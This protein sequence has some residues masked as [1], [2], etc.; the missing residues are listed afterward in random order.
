M[1]RIKRYPALILAALLLLSGC[2]QTAQEITNEE[3]AAYTAEV[4]L[5]EVDLEEELVALAETPPVPETLLLPAASGVLV[6]KNVLFRVHVL[7]HILVNVK[8]IRRDVCNH[9][10]V[11]TLSH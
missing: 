2:G 5:E 11:G 9:R 3:P 10:D 7:V 4:A 6:Q 1:K 8:M